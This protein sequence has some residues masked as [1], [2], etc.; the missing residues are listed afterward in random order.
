MDGNS[1]DRAVFREEL[2]LDTGRSGSSTGENQDF[3]VW[4]SVTDLVDILDLVVCKSSEKKLRTV[5]AV[6]HIQSRLL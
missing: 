3:L 5:S 4:Y 1:V 6:L 2:I